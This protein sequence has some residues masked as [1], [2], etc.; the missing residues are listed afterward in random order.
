MPIMFLTP[1]EWGVFIMGISIGIAIR[2]FMVGAVIA[3]GFVYLYRKSAATGKR[4]FYMHRVWRAGLPA[5]PLQK[6]YWPK[7]SAVDLI[8]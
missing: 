3:F 2:Q 6:K 8:E 1:I 5:D 7:P 4:G